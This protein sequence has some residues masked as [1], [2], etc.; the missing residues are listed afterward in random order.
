M[1]KIIC[2]LLTLAICL[3]LAAC[4]TPAPV[5]TSAPTTV[6]AT[7]AP[8]P[9]EPTPTQPVETQPV[10]TQPLETEPA[11]TEPALATPG[12][13]IAA[14]Y[15]LADGEALAEKVTLTGTVS[16][17]DTAWSEQYQNITVTMKVAGYEDKP[18][19]CYRLAGE[20]AKDLAYGDVITVTGTIK[21]Y[22]GIIEFQQGCGLDS[23]VKGTGEGPESP[24]DYDVIVAEAQALK[25]GQSLPYVAT[26]TGRVESIDY[27]YSAKYNDM[28][29]T[30][31]VRGQDIYCYR[32][33][34]P[35]TD[36]L[37]Q[38]GEKDWVTVMGKIK[39]YNGTIEF[40]GATMIAYTD[41]Y[42]VEGPEDPLEHIDA[43][44]E[45]KEGK[46]LEYESTL[47]G[48]IT[49][50]DTPWSDTYKNIT[51]TIQVPGRED[52]PIQCYRLSGEGADGLAVGDTITVTGTLK[53]YMGKVEFDQGCEV[54]DIVK[55]EAPVEPEEPEQPEEPTTLQYVTSVAT[56][57]AYKL[58]MNQTAKESIYFFTGTMSGY[59]GATENNYNKAIDVYLEE[60][61]GGFYLYFT[62]ANGAK[63][64]IN[65]VKSGTHY[66]FTFDDAAASVFEFD[67]EKD[68]LRTDVEGEVCY[69]GTYG[70]YVTVGVLQTSKMSETDYIARLYISSGSTETPD[71]PTDP[72]EPTTPS[73]P[74]NNDPA[75]DSA[76]SITDAAALGA[77]KAQDTFTEGKY[78][79]VGE[80]TEIKSTK[81]GNMTIK[82]EDG[83]TLYIFGTWNE[84][85]TV[86][87]DAL[88]TKPVVGDTVKLYGIIGNYNGAQMKNGWIVE[89]TPAETTPEET[90]PEE[91]IPEETTP[92]TTVPE[93]TTPET[94][95]PE[96][97]S[98]LSIADAATLGE[99]MEHNT[100]TEGKYYVI[101]EITEIKSTKYGNMIIKDAE[102]NTLY[103]YGTYSADGS[104]RYDSLETKPAVGDTV[105]LYGVIGNY[106][107][108]QMKDGWIVEHTPAPDSTLSIAAAAA[109]GE[110]MEHNTLTEGKYYVIGEIT[111]IKSTKY[112]N[113]TI[114]DESGNTL[115]IYGTWNEDGTVRYD[116]LETKP[117]VGDTVKLYGVIGNYNGAQMKNGW[118]IEHTP[119]TGDDED[120]GDETPTVDYVTD[121]A[122]GTAYKLGLENGSVYYFTGAMSG[123]YGVTT[124]DKSQGV[125]VYLESATDGFYLYFTDAN[126]VKQYINLIQSGTYYN[127]KYGTEAVSVFTFNGDKD[128]L[129]ADLSGEICYMGTYG[130]YTTFGALTTSKLKDTD[131]IG[132]LYPST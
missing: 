34:S 120:S 76:L 118:I 92:E 128:A 75:A 130:T 105:K 9:T 106:N 64:Y 43:A 93:E 81:Y 103:I 73:E 10:E 36:W 11:V 59:Y 80:I 58:G 129:C 77:S 110:S 17:V 50:V 121:P 97:D 53:N 2:W 71:E 78:Y 31:E 131:H 62:D 66:N 126:G 91:T 65:L 100:V 101:G 114:K 127:F 33:T 30:I 19:M 108:A 98:T 68:A 20:G 89:H 113:M 37:K 32:L 39:N 35:R 122:V 44:Y 12:D 23:V 42:K 14:A 107:G 124:T 69:M 104:T 3:G 115:Y 132:R 25:P 82:D 57:T 16:S 22:M 83:N 85:G 61:T 51:V 6:P 70:S 15:A 46:S 123:Y 95:V 119:A 47:T 18:V 96:A 7:L 5:E 48:V 55:G 72:S 28:S 87:Y 52:K 13:I 54:I 94:T 86:R 21:N 60:T 63:Q 26:L 117:A 90:T 74:E 38:V 27:A 8:T 88:E 67:E 102:G 79:V 1:K 99:S 29:I 40:D 112:G 116:A 45:L 4:G 41:F 84:D 56:G 24:I 111:E 49:S 125:D 109:L